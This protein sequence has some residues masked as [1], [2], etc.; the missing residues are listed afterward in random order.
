MSDHHLNRLGGLQKFDDTGSANTS[1][2]I[3]YYPDDIN[4]VSD[5]LSKY[6]YTPAAG[7]HLRFQRT[8]NGQAIISLLA[9]P[10][11]TDTISYLDYMKSAKMPMAL[12]Y[13]ASYEGRGRVAHAG[14]IIGNFDEPLTPLAAQIEVQQW[15]MHATDSVAGYVSGS[16]S[17]LVLQLLSPLP[18]SVYQGDWI[19]VTGTSNNAAQ[20]TGYS[21][22][23]F[24]N[25]PIRHISDDR[26]RVVVAVTDEGA[27]AAANIATVTAIPGTMFI[28]FFFN[29]LGATHGMGT[30]F[31]G[32]TTTSAAMFS[33]MGGDSFVT[34]AASNDIRG[35]QLV[36]V[37][38]TGAIYPPS[39]FGQAEIRP[40]T[41]YRMETRADECSFQ[42]QN[43]DSAA[44]QNA[45]LTRSSVK[46][47][48]DMELRP[49]A[50][51]R[52]PKGST[53]VQAKIV[54]IT[55]TASTTCTVTTDV[56]H[57][58]KVADLVTIRGVV[59][60]TNF[61]NSATNAPV[62]TVISATQFTV[63]WGASATATAYGGVVLK[64]RAA[65]EIPGIP[66]AQAVTNVVWNSTTQFLIL[67]GSGTWA[68][69]TTG[70]VVSL[71]GCIKVGG[72]DSGLDGLWRVHHSATNQLTLTPISD[73][74]GVRISPN[75][76]DY[77]GAAAGFVVIAPEFR[78]HDLSIEDWTE[79]RVIIDGA[80]VARAD[81]AIPTFSM[82]GAYS[83]TMTQGAGAVP[84]TSGTGSWIVR[85]GTAA[86]ADV[87]SAASTVTSTSA[88]I[89]NDLGNGFQVTFPVTAVTGSSPTLDIRIEES[90]DGGANWET[91]YEMQRINAAG[92]YNTPIL[93]ASGRHIRYVRTIGGSSPSFTMSITRNVLPFIQAEPQKR[94]MDRTIVPNTANS[95]T[96]VLFSG[97]ANNVQLVVNM[98]AITTTAPQYQ[99]EGSEDRQ[100]GWYPIGA[101]LLAVANSTVEQTVNKSATFIRVRVSAA[102]AGA[103]LGYISLKAWS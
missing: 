53:T 36:S 97:A 59:D 9:D 45:R 78:I 60:Q 93:R 56:P 29:M 31:S 92:S 20:T 100:S 66:V 57:G 49:R 63:V 77:S 68:G 80:G 85:P 62:A 18:A 1:G 23:E 82:G 73:A 76:V 32:A 83:G 42:D 81:K 3:N 5:V 34:A 52:I 37:G 4:T 17:F 47:N 69:A 24:A 13:E 12:E 79:H 71:K 72:S 101:P 39:S 86:I 74:F 8:V 54:S 6:K 58:L 87:A 50:Y 75:P 22:Q 21:G 26:T 48:A 91:L 67:T 103:T 88:A 27:I 14:M 41:R 38:T 89:A 11:A 16:G 25:C 84:G 40:T 2:A 55:K 43:C 61:A 65:L 64:H 46:P 10:A 15:W 33:S 44:I 90:F 94:L 35:S 99:V 102:G 95:T 51:L 19:N 28:S 96:P 7:H 30:R 70:V 98:G